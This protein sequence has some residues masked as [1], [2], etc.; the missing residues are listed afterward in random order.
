MTTQDTSTQPTDD[1][2]EEFM[3]TFADE[4]GCIHD[5][6]HA[7]CA[8]AVLARYGDVRTI[9]PSDISEIMIRAALFQGEPS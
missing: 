6:S 5:D 9:G 7:E 3:G 1:D 2:L 8:R 4:M